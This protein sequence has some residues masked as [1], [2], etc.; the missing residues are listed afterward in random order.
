[1]PAFWHRSGIRL[2]GIF[3]NPRNSYDITFDEM[4]LRK[5]AP[6]V[7]LFPGYVP[8]SDRAR[9]IYDVERTLNHGAVPRWLARVAGTELV[10]AYS[11]GGRS[12]PWPSIARTAACKSV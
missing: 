1:M 11:R 10:I 5:L 6:G 3:G 8:A 12:R 2:G 4:D 7:T 9:S